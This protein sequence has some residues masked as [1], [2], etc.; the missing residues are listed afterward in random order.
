MSQMPDE[1]TPPTIA[2]AVEDYINMRVANR[3]HNTAR[4]YTAGLDK[5]LQALKKNKLDPAH[6]PTSVLEEKHMAMFIR[7]LANLSASSEQTYVTD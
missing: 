5:F 1:I 2:K 6:S 7:S 4:T 3:S